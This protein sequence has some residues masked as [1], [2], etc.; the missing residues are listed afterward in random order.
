MRR[1]ALRSLAR[2][3]LTLSPLLVALLSRGT[4]EA[5]G[6]FDAESGSVRLSKTALATFDFEGTS[7]LG[8]IELATWVEGQGGWPALERA[9]LAKEP[10]LEGRLTTCED[11]IEGTHALRLGDAG[12][13]IALTDPS[14]LQKVSGG[15]FEVTLWAR[16]D[17]TAPMLG[18]LYDR[19]PTNIDR[20]GAQFASVRGI[21]TGRETSDGWAEYS[22][23]PIE[24]SV[25]GA[26]AVAILV[27]SGYGADPKATFLVDALEVSAIE[28]KPLA[29]LACTQQ[30]VDAVCGAEGDC[31]FG[32][33]VPSSVTWGVFPS[34]EHRSRIA[35]RWVHFGTRVIGDRASARLGATVLTPGARELATSASGARQF[36][37]GMNR[38]VNLLRDNHT[39]F[40]GPS[41]FTSFAPQ[42]QQGTSSTLGACFGVVEKDIAGGGLGYAVFRAAES[43]RTKV[44]LQ[45]GD[46]LVSVDGR[47]PKEWVDEI[48]PRY[49]T[50]LPNDARADWGPSANDLSRL[51]TMRA[52]KVTLARCASSAA[53]TDAAREL[54]EIDVASAIYGSLSA[55]SAGT[56]GVSPSFSCSQRFTDSVT[57]TAPRGYGEDVVRSGPGEVGETR[58]QFDGFVGQGTWEDSM[59][60]IFEPKPAR[61]MMDARMGHGGYYSAVEHLFHLLR[62]TKEPMGVISLGRGTYD[63]TDPAWLFPE[64]GQCTTPSGGN[65]WKCFAGNA[66]GFFATKA[67]PP[68]A[69]TRIAWLNTYDVSANDFMPKLL[70]GRSGFRIFGPHPT[71]GAFGAV[72]SLPSVISGWSGG[73]IQIQDSRFASSLA[74]ATSARW[75]SGHGVPPDEVVAQK[76]SDAVLGTDTILK[77]A[78]AWLATQ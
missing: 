19:D 59:T 78:S 44:K 2:S 55:P 70:S 1:P 32:H 25:W 7:N 26:P 11:A 12:R 5:R 52:S 3:A 45:R 50:A 47:D 48:W 21:R 77:A 24:G 34:A 71:A 73:S 42:V 57:G 33:C 58:V 40:G 43:P 29:P 62:G 23:G 67:D 56:D 51:I 30:T 36:F 37:G 28:G 10:S 39:N 8:G 61:V 75:E 20:F 17:G 60:K 65:M 13:G 18:V 46:L 49:A 69:A 66:I 72:V 35:E 74:E 41:N 64:L 54:I 31:M 53:C 16:A 63:M 9:P 15:R 4:A 14:L 27:L 38:L 6:T 22:T 76:L 68:G